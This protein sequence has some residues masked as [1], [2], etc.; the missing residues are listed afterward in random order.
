MKI[1]MMRKRVLLI[2]T[3]QSHIGQFHKPLMRL[4]KQNGWEIHVA[5]R[6]NLD[7]KD[8]LQLEYPDQVFDVPFQRSPLDRRN[9]GAFRVLKQI[10]RDNHYDVIHCNTP[11]GGILGRIAAQEY[12]RKGTRVYYTVHGFH[13]YKGA[14]SRNW[15]IYY[16]IEKWMSRL[17]DKL[18][19]ISEEDYKMAKENF[20]CPVYHIHGAGVNSTRYYPLSM[21]EQERK[22]KDLCMEGHVLVN[23]GELRPNKNQK[24]AIYALKHILVR[25]PDTHLY[26]AGNGQEREKLEKIAKDQGLQNYITFLGYTLKLSD[27]LQVCDAEVACSYREGLPFNVVEAMLCGKPVVASHN[28]GHDELVEEGK[29][30]YL[31]APNDIEGYAEAVCRV[32]ENP[33]SFR[34]ESIHKAIVYKDVA[35][36]KELAEVYEL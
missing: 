17:T 28:R 24:T 27:Y 16:P 3:L 6:N 26:I 8:G 12:R 23:A 4:L 21:E 13:F 32:F 9:I 35:V 7:E 10:L 5:A 18:I 30:G 20:H 14:P 29:T 31:V 22:K 1:G 33:V 25:F 19:T 11:V 34:E 15:I 36:Q 2:A